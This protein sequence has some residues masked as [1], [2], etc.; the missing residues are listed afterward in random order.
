MQYKIGEVIKGRISGV[1]PYGA[2]VNLDQENSGLIHISE[3][4][5]GFVKDV[6]SIF[7]VGE[8]IEAKIIDFDD[9]HYKLSI[10]SLRQTSTR[11]RQRTYKKE[12]LPPMI[13]GFKT[14]ADQL[15]QWIV[16]ANALEENDD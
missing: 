15:D 6:H 8:E 10:K 12:K 4:S 13:L 1:Q 11:S 9:H 7:H 3:I 5:N 2:F 14:L 16:I